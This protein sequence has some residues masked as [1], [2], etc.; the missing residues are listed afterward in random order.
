MFMELG[1]EGIVDYMG[2]VV[3]AKHGIDVDEFWRMFAMNPLAFWGIF[4]MN[5]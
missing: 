1:F 5:K 3:E 4:I 2:L